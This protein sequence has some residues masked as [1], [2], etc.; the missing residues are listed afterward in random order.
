MKRA[1]STK[2]SLLRDGTALVGLLNAEPSGCRNS[3]QRVSGPKVGSLLFLVPSS[4]R[5]LFPPVLF[6]SNRE[7]GLR[8]RKLFPQAAENPPNSQFGPGI[9]G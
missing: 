1:G 4:A 2:L 5:Q 9:C 8:E 6:N 3:W 7:N